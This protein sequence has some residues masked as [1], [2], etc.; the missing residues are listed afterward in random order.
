M[1]SSNCK[2]SAE[3]LKEYQELTFLSKQEIIK[4]FNRYAEIIGSD[5]DDDIFRKGVPVE[6]IMVCIYSIPKPITYFA[7]YNFI[8]FFITVMFIANRRI[9]S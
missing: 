8:V 6:T 4:V 5:E 9:C 1:G 3:Q 7:M 2:L